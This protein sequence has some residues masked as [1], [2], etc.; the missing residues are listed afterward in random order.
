MLLFN[1]CTREYV[2]PQINF[3][4]SKELTSKP[5]K[6]TTTNSKQGSLFNSTSGLYSSNSKDL[7]VGDIVTVN[8]VENIKSDSIGE[9]KADKTNSSD[10][11]GGLAVAPATAYGGVN[12]LVKNVNNLTG[13]GFQTKSANKFMGKTSAKHSEKFKASV[14]AIIQ[15]VLPNGNYF[16]VGQKEILVDG[17]KQTIMLSGI[18]RPYDVKL[19]DNKVDSSKIANAK[20]MYK[21][22][23]MER[24]STV[25]NWG[26]TVL[27]NVWPF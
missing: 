5:K 2:E 9:R 4:P 20:I 21:K 7:N 14:A 25:K 1:G 15:N 10:L 26:T 11:G 3:N 27:E 8:V 16:I 24:D 22:Q 19:P 6:H 12:K 13:I 23:G 18:V 17:Q